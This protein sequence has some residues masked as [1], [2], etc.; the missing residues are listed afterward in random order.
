MFN[1]VG[2]TFSGFVS[3]G[4]VSVGTR[5]SVPTFVGRHVTSKIEIGIVRAP[6]E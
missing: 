3:R 1:R 6:T 5:C 4:K 2:G